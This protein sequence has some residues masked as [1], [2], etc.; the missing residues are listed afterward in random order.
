MAPFSVYILQADQVIFLGG[1]QMMNDVMLTIYN[2]FSSF[3]RR[4]IDGCLMAVFL[5]EEFW[6]Y[7]TE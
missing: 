3:G 1:C 5:D 7:I 4:M 6:S 2:Q